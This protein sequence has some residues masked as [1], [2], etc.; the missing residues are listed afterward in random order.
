VKTHGLAPV[1]VKEGE[2][3]AVRQCE[4]VLRSLVP[5]DVVHAVHAVVVPRDDDAAHQLL[6]TLFL[7]ALRG[8]LEDQFP[9][10]Q[11][12]PTKTHIHNSTMFSFKLIMKGI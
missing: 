1:I 10:G 9:K 4:R 7:E 2:V 8:L 5:V 11:K 12:T 6:G 3:G